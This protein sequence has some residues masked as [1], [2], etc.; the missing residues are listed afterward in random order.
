MLMNS[1]K[2]D[3]LGMKCILMV[4]VECF[5]KYK[6]ENRKSKDRMD[7][8]FNCLMGEPLVFR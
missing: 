1:K 5:Y 6:N 3:M 2:C 8:L 7:K 4:G